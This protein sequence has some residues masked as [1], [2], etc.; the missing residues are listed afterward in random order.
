M[1][2]KRFKN[3]LNENSNLKRSATSMSKFGI[4]SGIRNWIY[5][6]LNIET[7]NFKILPFIKEEEILKHIEKTFN[8]NN[9]D[10]KNYE[11]NCGFKKDKIMFAY[12]KFENDSQIDIS[13]KHGPVFEDSFNDLKLYDE[14]YYI[15]ELHKDGLLIFYLFNNKEDLKNRLKEQQDQDLE[16]GL[17]AKFYE[18][19]LKFKF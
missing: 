12:T 16:L 4:D 18:R 1:I 19:V 9:S 2:I 14:L 3:F 17:N 7:L 5:F 13:T 15:T 10:L 11:K 6:E 8:I